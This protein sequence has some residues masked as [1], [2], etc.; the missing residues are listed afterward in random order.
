[1]ELEILVQRFANIY[2]W[3]VLAY[4]I[5]NNINMSLNT[6]IYQNW[7]KSQEIK[8]KKGEYE[9]LTWGSIVFWTI[10]ILSMYYK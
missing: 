3:V 9:M 7:K 2:F 6:I 10:W 1:M 8:I 5:L 4:I